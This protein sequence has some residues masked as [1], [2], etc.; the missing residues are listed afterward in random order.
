MASSVN[1]DPVALSEAGW[2]RFTIFR[3][4]YVRI[5]TVNTIKLLRSTTNYI[6]I[7]E[8]VNG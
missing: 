1:P 3:G 6:F 8:F 5:F 7:L 4:M 2:S